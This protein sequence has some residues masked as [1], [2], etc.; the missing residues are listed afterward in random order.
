[1]TGDISDWSKCTL[2]KQLRWHVN[3]HMMRHDGGTN[4]VALL[5]MWQ[6]M[7]KAWSERVYMKYIY[8]MAKY[9]KGHNCSHQAALAQPEM[10]LLPALMYAKFHWRPERPHSGGKSP[11]KLLYCLHRRSRVVRMTTISWL[12]IP[13]ALALSYANLRIC[14]HFT[15]S[16]L[17]K[18]GLHLVIMTSQDMKVSQPILS[19]L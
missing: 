3:V 2:L 5:M 12:D 1:M 4:N 16:Y 8:T 7:L 19:R 17:Q 14:Q 6:C 9:V 10:L 13:K 18:Q 15:C 11:L